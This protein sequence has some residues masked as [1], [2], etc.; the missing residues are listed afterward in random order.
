MIPRGR[1]QSSA[2]GFVFVFG[3]I[4]VTVGVVTAVGIP[5]LEDAR[6]TER[7]DNMERAFEVMADNFADVSRSEAPSRATEV[8]LTGGSLALVPSTNVS[9]EAHDAADPDQNMS[10][11]NARPRPIA[12]DD[13][14]TEIALVAGS[15]IR[16]DGGSTVLSGPGWIVSEE[17]TVLPMVVTRSSGGS[18]SLG[19]D[20]TA[21]VVAEQLG[22][23][24]ARSYAADNDTI[25]EVT[26][27][28]P[29]ADGWG[30][31][32]AD[33]GFDCAG[34]ADPPGGVTCRVETDELVIPEIRV[35]VSISQ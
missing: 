30:R 11:Y 24:V 22:R 12:Y 1:A 9:V 8:K 18:T 3:I 17:R 21:L 32:L 31:H 19:G 29:R 2:I 20:L 28:S 26:V 5:V 14:G 6:E 13:A 23:D 10:T 4:V 33:V 25:V 7:I 15:V 27:R 16:T 35:G 34:P